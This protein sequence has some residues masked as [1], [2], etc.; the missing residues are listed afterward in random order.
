MKN[1]D[2]RRRGA[3]VLGPLP[4]TGE[5]VPV[6]INYFIS[7]LRFSSQSLNPPKFFLASSKARLSSLEKGF[8]RLAHKLIHLTSVHSSDTT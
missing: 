7:Y 2:G 4:P 5:L 8:L 3:W 1:H 6:I